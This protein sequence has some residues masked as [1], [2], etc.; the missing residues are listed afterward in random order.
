MLVVKSK[1]KEYVGDLNVS[2]DFADALDGAV[3]ELIEKAA[4]RAKDNG[5]KTVQSRD[6]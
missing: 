2:S 6:L 5:R 3:K 1:I 4:K